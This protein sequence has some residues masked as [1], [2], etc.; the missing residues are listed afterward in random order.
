MNDQEFAKIFEKF[1]AFW[2]VLEKSLI[3]EIIMAKYDS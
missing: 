3:E 1:R 2:A